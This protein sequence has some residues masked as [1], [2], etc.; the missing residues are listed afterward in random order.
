MTQNRLYLIV[1]FAHSGSSIFARILNSTPHSINIG[2]INNFYKYYKRGDACSCGRLIK[3]CEFWNSLIKSSGDDL[4][5]RYRDIFKRRLLNRKI[6]YNK[7]VYS[8]I[9]N[10]CIS[11]GSDER[12]SI[13]DNSKHPLRALILAMNLRKDYDIKVMFTN[14]PSVLMLESFRKRKNNQQKGLIEKR[15]WLFYPIYFFFI[16]YKIAVQ[17]VL[18][19]S[20]IS[21]ENIDT[22]NFLEYIKRNRDELNI[23]ER[24]PSQYEIQDFCNHSIGGS[25]SSKGSLLKV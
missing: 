16:G 5:I 25:G 17:A 21:Y 23:I 9:T 19:I 15:I 14:K 11:S 10:F 13:V 12:I 18:W 3:D 1:G 2:E 22:S 20:R 8:K 24:S 7:T 6:N 4:Y